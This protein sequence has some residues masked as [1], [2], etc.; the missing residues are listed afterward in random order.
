MGKHTTMAKKGGL[1]K[2]SED[3]LIIQNKFCNGGLDFNQFSPE[4][5]RTSRPD[6]MNYIKNAF[7]SS[8]KML[9]TNLQIEILTENE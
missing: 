9:A 4:T 3:Y 2:G 5:L 8:I 6:W 7:A 1:S